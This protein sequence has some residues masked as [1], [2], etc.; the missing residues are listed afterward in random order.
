MYKR[1]YRRKK[2]GEDSIFEI[3]S[4]LV[5]FGVAYLAFVY[6]VNRGQFWFEMKHYIFPTLG[7]IVFIVGV[8]LF[9]MLQNKKR[10]ERHFEGVIQQITGT[11]LERKV[12]SYL[13]V[14]FLET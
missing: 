6:Y 11:D 10:K 13:V 14:C 3:V 4:M 1:Y 12:N 5:V 7:I 9:Y 8:S 2:G